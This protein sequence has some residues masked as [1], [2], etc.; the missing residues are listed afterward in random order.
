MNEQLV[1]PLAL[2]VGAVVA[3][4][5]YYARHL[6]RHRVRRISIACEVNA[7]CGA[8]ILSVALAAI[9]AMFHNLTGLGVTGFLFFASLGYATRAG[10][11]GTMP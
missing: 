4:A 3:A 10:E 1:V 9:C 11:Y 7:Y 6:L 5:A 8:I 2:C